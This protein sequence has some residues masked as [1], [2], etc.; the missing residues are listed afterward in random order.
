MCNHRDLETVIGLEIRD[1]LRL[2]IEPTNLSH[3]LPRTRL[4]RESAPSA[5][6]YPAVDFG[7]VQRILPPVSMATSRKDQGAN[8]PE[9]L[10]L[11]NQRSY[12]GLQGAEKSLSRM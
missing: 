6:R 8:I 4:A 3:R 7:S 10:A 5:E 11:W 12:D 2:Q 9:V 1:R